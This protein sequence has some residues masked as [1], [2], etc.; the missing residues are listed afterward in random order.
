VTWFDNPG[1][2]TNGASGI[3]ALRVWSPAGVTNVNLGVTIGGHVRFVKEGEGG[4]KAAKAYQTYTGGNHV[5]EGT[6]VCG[7]AQKY[8]PLGLTNRV[9]EI[10]VSSNG[11]FDAGGQLAWSR[12]LMVLDGGIV[13]NSNADANPPAAQIGSMRLE[14]D[15]RM[16]CSSSY[17][18]TAVDS[19]TSYVN[20]N[21][22][23]L[24][25]VVED[26][27]SFNFASIVA[28]NGTISIEGGTF[29]VGGHNLVNSITNVATNVN[30][31]VNSAMNI[32]API[33]VGGYEALYDGNVNT[34]TAMLNIHGTFKPSAHD[35]FHGCEMQD[36]S[37]MDLSSRTN[38]LPIV[39]TFTTGDNMLK[40]A[41][42]ATI[43]VKL[44][45][46][47]VSLRNPIISWDSASKPT[48]IDTVKFVSAPGERKHSFVAQN[49]GLYALSGL[50]IIV[51]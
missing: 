29:R 12:W 34:G 25:A 35:C 5:F 9:N 33:N 46:R 39:S 19:A 23:T 28:E 20:L 14:A 7:Y 6:L 32:S 37:T 17:G 3:A 40:F 22:Y 44:G 4:F 47:L 13:Q 30:F 27:K 18:I 49:D 36:G 42:G 26:G 16:L 21:G 45:E 41:N 2:V 51:K 11:V 24:H 1:I 43:S 15:S 31:I 48:G 50:M 10:V 38:A 8:N